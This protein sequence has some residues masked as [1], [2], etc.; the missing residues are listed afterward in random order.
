MLNVT[1][2]GILL[3]LVEDR[4]L[5]QNANYRD[6]HPRIFS[7]SERSIPEFLF[8]GSQLQKR[9]FALNHLP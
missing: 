9:Y 3:V 8:N 4:R 1:R 7:R 2:S 5:Y 6:R